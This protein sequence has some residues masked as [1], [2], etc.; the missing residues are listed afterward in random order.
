MIRRR[1]A[2]PSAGPDPGR[3]SVLDRAQRAGSSRAT[4]GSRATGGS[5]T[6]GHAPGT[7]VDFPRQRRS[8]TLRR[9]LLPLVGLLVVLG[10]LVA[11]AVFSPVLAL[12]T[13]VVQGQSLTTAAEVEEALEP[14]TGTSLTRISE[15]DVRALLADKAPIDDVGIAAEPPSTLVVTVVEH[16]PVAV[17]QEGEEF[18]LID[19]EGR[20]LTSVPNRDDV[21][22]PLIAGGTEAVNST[23]FSSLAAVLE[24][25]PDSVLSRLTSASASS[26]DSIR[27]SLEGDQLIFWGSAERS[28]E[29]A[30]V[31]E[32]LLAAASEE[33][34]VTE[35]DVS[36][37]DRPVTR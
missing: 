21:E 23:V 30:L 13:V 7:V 26:V 37:P 15:D 24:E 17:L 29:K 18:V 34:P 9:I 25:V 3:V 1:P 19:A 16:K 11:F 33:Q 31:V 20:H 5:R 28:A 36:T 8:R 10:S 14:L 2:T 27:L 32:A 22:L 4:E 6:S 35:F 12:R